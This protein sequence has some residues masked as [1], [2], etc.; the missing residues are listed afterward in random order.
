MTLRDRGWIGLSLLGGSPYIIRYNS[1][2]PIVVYVPEG[3]E[4][5]Y[6]VWRAEPEMETNAGG[7]ALNSI[8]KHFFCQGADHDFTS[9]T[10]SFF[11]AF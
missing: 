10:L 8:L 7:P 4:V 5:R 1:S 9:G 11:G 6:R 3:M 2:L